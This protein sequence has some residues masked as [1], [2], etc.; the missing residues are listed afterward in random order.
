MDEAISAERQDAA[1]EGVDNSRLEEEAAP[2][3]QIGEEELGSTAE[4]GGQLVEH[5]AKSEATASSFAS[6]S[7]DLEPPTPLLIGDTTSKILLLLPKRISRPH[8][9]S[10]LF[11][12]QGPVTQNQQP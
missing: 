11:H 6:I 5:Q 2:V 7:A 10:H 12:K 3:A 8:K 4:S 1:G 9:T